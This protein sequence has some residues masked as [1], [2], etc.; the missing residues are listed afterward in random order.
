MSLLNEGTNADSSNGGGSTNTDSGSGTSTSTNSGVS[1][2]WKDSL[3][4]DIRGHSAIATF[5][6]PATLAKSYIH[7]QGLIGKKGVLVPGEKA[8]DDDWNS[9]YDSLGRPP[10]DKYALDNSK[11][12][13]DPAALK[14]FSEA[15]HKA[16][17]LPKQAQAIMEMYVGGQQADVQAQQA[18][19]AKMVEDN[20]TT[21]QKEW[22]EG[23]PKMINAAVAAAKRVGGDGFIEYLAEK[24]LDSDVR[25]I[26]TL[27]EVGKLLGEDKFRGEANTKLGMT[28]EEAQ[29]EINE[30]QSRPEY[31]D[32]SHGDHKKVV[33]R[34]SDLYQKLFS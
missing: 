6:D 12:N 27:A 34:V 9:F 8:S 5:D 11:I 25:I 18:V 31:G 24:G 15:F 4:E 14:G 20:K 17:L 28:P 23:Y 22:G 7:A 33:N 19:K 10:V 3:P 16:G 21:L 1:T 32:P 30:L 2:S 13:L 29:R 26:K